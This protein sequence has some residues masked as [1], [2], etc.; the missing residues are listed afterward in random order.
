MRDAKAPRS[1]CQ[2]VAMALN[3]LGT[4]LQT[5]SVAPLT[6]FYRTGCCETGAEDR[7]IHTVCVEV[8][9]EFL[10][11][12]ASVGN[13]LSTPQP[14]FPGLRGGDRW[15]LCATRWTDALAAGKAPKVILDDTH[16]AMLEFADLADLRAHSVPSE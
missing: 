4:E 5:C 9:E 3:V 11:Y 10:E 15:C 16:A 12:S 2:T 6:G 13:D 1:A 14:G 8:T 7:G